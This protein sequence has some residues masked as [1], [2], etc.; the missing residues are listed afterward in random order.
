MSFINSQ[1]AATAFDQISLN[2]IKAGFPGI[3]F[4]TGGLAYY[5]LSG[6][7]KIGGMGMGNAFWNVLSTISGTIIAHFVWNEEISNKQMLGIG[8]GAVSLFLMDGVQI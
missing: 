3:V 5:S 4:I 2:A 1:V 8:F 7:I 6:A